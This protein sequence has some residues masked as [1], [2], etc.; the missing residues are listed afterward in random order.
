MKRVGSYPFFVVIKKGNYIRV[1][2]TRLF[3]R[4]SP[5][6]LALEYGLG[7]SA[8]NNPHF[9]Q[10]LYNLLKNRCFTNSKGEL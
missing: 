2:Q 9:G 7:R 6:G 5:F 1:I 10:L 4:R 8:L 3:L